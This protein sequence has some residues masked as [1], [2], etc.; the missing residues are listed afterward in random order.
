[1]NS[2]LLQKHSPVEVV[3]AFV[4]LS[5]ILLNPGSL[6]PS[7]NILPCF[8]SDL[9]NIR[10]RI[11]LH[12]KHGLKGRQKQSLPSVTVHLDRKSVV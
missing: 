1:M 3:S 8:P 6:S 9:L 5:E 4:I 7:L 12:P 10:R 2:P 11:L